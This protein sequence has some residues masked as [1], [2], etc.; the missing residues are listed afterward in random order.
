MAER[1]NKCKLC[2]RILVR[3]SKTGL[4]PVCQ[5]KVRNYAVAGGVAV[6]V[7]VDLIKKFGWPIVKKLILNR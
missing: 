6:T 3:E 2:G 1:E 5:E 7:I 4:C